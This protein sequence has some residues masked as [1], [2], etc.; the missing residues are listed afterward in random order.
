LSHCRLH[1]VI[2]KRGLELK[3]L[4]ETNFADAVYNINMNN[5]VVNGFIKENKYYCSLTSS[6]I[7]HNKTFEYIKFSEYVKFKLF[8]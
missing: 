2:D 8:M 4:L 7:N 6:V 1:E 3:N 5:T